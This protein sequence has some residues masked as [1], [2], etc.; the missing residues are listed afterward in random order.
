MRSWTI[1]LPW[2]APPLSLNDRPKNW[3]AHARKVRDVRFAAG[4]AAAAVLR[5][6]TCERID[7]TLA[8]Y[9]RDKRRRDP[10]NLTATQKP[11][12]DALVDCGLI[13]DDTP[14]YLTDRL[15][16]IHAP[17]GDPRLTLTITELP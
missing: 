2:T 8:Y 15:P 10:L 16:V 14:Q 4:Q 12:V 9:P 13:P 7:V 17:D 1:R 5:G 11:I 3:A 6:A